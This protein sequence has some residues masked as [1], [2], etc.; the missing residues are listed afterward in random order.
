MRTRLQ[1][2]LPS[3]QSRSSARHLWHREKTN[4]NDEND[5]EILVIQMANIKNYKAADR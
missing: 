4:K 1:A 2:Q 5:D 3:R